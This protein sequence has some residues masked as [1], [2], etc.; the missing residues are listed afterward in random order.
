MFTIDLND[1]PEFSR[2]RLWTLGIS[3]N[4][5]VIRA[6]SDPEWYPKTG[7][8]EPCQDSRRRFRSRLIG[9]SEIVRT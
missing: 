3:E 4:A 8:F 5:G 1:F 2:V 6:H 9:I 7:V